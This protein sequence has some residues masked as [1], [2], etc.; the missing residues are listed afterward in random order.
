LEI[1]EVIYQDE[2]KARVKSLRQFAKDKQ[3]SLNKRKDIYFK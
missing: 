2:K 3:F 1:R